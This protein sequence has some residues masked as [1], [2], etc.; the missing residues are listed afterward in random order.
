MAKTAQE[1]Y[2]EIISYVRQSGGA[3]NTWYAGITADIEKRL[4]GDHNVSKESSY[5]IWRRASSTGSARN[6]EEALLK[7]GFDGGSGGGDNTSDCV[8]CYKKSAITEP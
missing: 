5:W 6:I 1:I 8:Y 3:N 7:D 2:D 4:H